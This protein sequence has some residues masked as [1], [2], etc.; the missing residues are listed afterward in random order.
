MR[1]LGRSPAASRSEHA[2][3]RAYRL[4]ASIGG[5][6]GAVAVSLA[7]GPHRVYRVAWS[8]KGSAAS[9]VAGAA[10]DAPN[11]GPPSRARVALHEPRR[12]LDVG[13]QFA[14]RH[15]SSSASISCRNSTTRSG[16]QKGASSSRNSPCEAMARFGRA[17]EQAR[18]AGRRSCRCMLAQRSHEPLDAGSHVLVAD[19]VEVLEH[20]QAES[21]SWPGS[22]GRE[23]TT[24]SSHVGHG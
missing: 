8:L 20:P 12:E 23:G 3:S 4:I 6:R 24:M 5:R 13:E 18:S 19:H 16:L 11:E 9:R 1:S 10:G 14:D 21:G 2:R 22:V 17:A 15:Q 7:P